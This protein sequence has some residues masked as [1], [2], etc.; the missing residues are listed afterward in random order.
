[1]ATRSLH[2]IVESNPPTRNDFVPKIGR[3]VTLSAL[4]PET[5]RLAEGISA[6]ATEAQARRNARRYPSLGR[7]IATLS[8]PDNA[9]V[10]VERTRGPG[11]HT[12]WG[13]PAT[14]LDLVVRV[15]PVSELY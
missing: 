3:L 6:Y 14:M 9:T 7:F 2:R 10:V 13:D 4:D 1:M 5:Q 12:I 8:V 15:T 11:H